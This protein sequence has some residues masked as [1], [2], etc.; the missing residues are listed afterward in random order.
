[1]RRPNSTG[2]SIQVALQILRRHESTPVVT[3]TGDVP[4]QFQR[5]DL[6]LAGVQSQPPPVRIPSQRRNS[7]GRCQTLIVQFP[8]T[9][10]ALRILRKLAPILASADFAMSACKRPRQRLCWSEA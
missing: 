8:F 7:S 9:R 5:A 2:L 1:M 4:Y 10:S 6:R 3:P